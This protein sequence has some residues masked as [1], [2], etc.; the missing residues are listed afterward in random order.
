MP[1]NSLR[2]VTTTCQSVSGL[3]SLNHCCLKSLWFCFNS[4]PWPITFSHK[5]KVKRKV[6]EDGKDKQSERVPSLK[7]LNEDWPLQTYSLHCHT[8]RLCKTPMNRRASSES[9]WWLSGAG[10]V[11]TSIGQIQCPKTELQTWLPMKAT[12]GPHD[13]MP[14]PLQLG[15]QAVCTVSQREQGFTVDTVLQFYGSTADAAGIRRNGRASRCQEE[16]RQNTMQKSH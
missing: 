8:Q 10:I 11:L 4:L 15:V 9:H 14:A 13:R 2:Y 6:K 5:V 3:R 16:G 7:W 12:A 1:H